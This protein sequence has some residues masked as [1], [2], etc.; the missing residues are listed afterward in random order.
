MTKSSNTEMKHNS[1]QGLK[2]RKGIA[3]IYMRWLFIAGLIPFYF[4]LPEDSNMNAAFLETLA[5]AVVYNVFVMLNVRK[6]PG[7]KGFIS[8]F[9]PYIDVILLAIFIYQSGGVRSDIYIIYLFLISYWGIKSDSFKTILISIFCIVAFTVSSFLSRGTMSGDFSFLSLLIRNIF[10]MI[11]AIGAS[12]IKSEVK[13]FDEM[14]KKEFKLARTDKLTGL[15]NR[16]YFD[17]KLNEEAE[18]S[19]STGNPL[20]ILIFDIDN[21]KKFNDSYGHVWGDK[22]LTLFSDIVKQNIRKSD[23]PVRFGGEEFLII[24]RDLDSFM[25]KSVGDRIRRQLENQKIYIGSDQ[26]RRK[27]TVSCG[28]AQYPKHSRNIREVVELADK[29]LYKAKESGKN[30]VVSYDEMERTEFG[31]DT[32]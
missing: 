7:N 24:I 14:H 6:K 25:A 29:A 31:L 20:N 9:S 16:H 30:K 23:I 17:Q 8:K 10:I 28:V 26:D 12:S 13:K 32:Y 21:F 2:L 27:V 5:V 11:C 3:L 22:L 19:D 1:G 18:Y 4:L 15:A